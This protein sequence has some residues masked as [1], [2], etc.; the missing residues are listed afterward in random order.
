LRRGARDLFANAHGLGVARA[1][2]ASFAA[3]FG[4]FSQLNRNRRARGVFRQTRQGL[5]QRLFGLL[6]VA[7]LLGRNAFAHQRGGGLIGLVI[8]L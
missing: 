5:L 7:L 8:S 2:V 4:E 3:L 6:G 1:R